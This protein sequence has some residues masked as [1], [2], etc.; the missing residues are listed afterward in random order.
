MCHAAE[1]RLRFSDV[2]RSEEAIECWVLQNNAVLLHHVWLLPGLLMD[3]QG[4]K[5]GLDVLPDTDAHVPTAERVTDATN[6]SAPC[7]H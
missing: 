1:G 3:M 5:R 4:I 2:H 7:L 6:M